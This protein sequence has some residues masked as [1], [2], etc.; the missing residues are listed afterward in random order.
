MKPLDLFQLLAVFKVAMSGS[1]IPVELKLQVAKEVL[2][3]LPPVAL[4]SPCPF[5][6][7]WLGDSVQ[8]VIDDL[9]AE[10]HERNRANTKDAEAPQDKAQ[11]IGKRKARKESVGE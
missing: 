4:C 11:T 9:K 1:E 6:R 3:S 10:Q 7:Q 2:H 8:G 5:T